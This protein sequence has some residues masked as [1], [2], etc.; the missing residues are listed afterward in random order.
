MVAGQGLHFGQHAIAYMA[1]ISAE[2]LNTYFL[3]LFS[4]SMR[5]AAD[6]AAR[7][8]SISPMPRKHIIIGPF[9]PHS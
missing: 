9:T 1:R 6:I 2:A 7:M 5:Q 3:R 8:L 4:R